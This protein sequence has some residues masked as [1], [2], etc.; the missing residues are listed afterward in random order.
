MSRLVFRSILAVTVATGALSAAAPALASD[1]RFSV[2]LRSGLGYSRNPFL[3]TGETGSGSIEFGVTPEL[4]IVDSLGTTALNA[5]YNRTEWFRRYSASDNYGAGLT[6]D[7]QLSA[8][9]KMTA[10][11]DYDSSVLALIDPIDVP[12]IAGRQRRER[13]VG[14]LGF[15]YQPGARDTIS[16]DGSVMHNDYGRRDIGTNW[17][18]T[19]TLGYDRGL[20]ETSSIGGR[21]TYS[22]SDYRGDFDSDVVTPQLVYKNRF[23]GGWNLEA[24]VGL[25]Y[26]SRP[27]GDD[28]SLSADLSLCKEDERLTLCLAGS[29]AS[30]STGY[31]S[32]RIETMVEASGQYRTS[33]RGTLS[34]AASYSRSNGEDI[35]FASRRVE[36]LRGNLTYEHALN[37]DISVGAE[38]RYRDIDDQVSVARKAD[39]SGQVF[40]RAVVGER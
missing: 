1:T 40:I 8:R 13:Y 28:T 35:F 31:G 2:D 4:Q 24:G 7:R 5:R 29:R 26:I 37:E 17:T 27:T 22:R 33:E 38:T 12:L 6:S 34:A 14:S 15:V 32:V 10:R 25:I 39:V 20:T 19:G 18:Y 11:L 30:Q 9:T 3:S 16:V 36:Y 23:A 21:V